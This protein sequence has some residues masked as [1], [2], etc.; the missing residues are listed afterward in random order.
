MKVKLIPLTQGKMAIVSD[1]DYGRVV[2]AGKWQAHRNQ[3]GNWY[4][5]RKFQIGKGKRKTVFM[6]R[7]IMEVTDDETHVD[8]LDGNGLNNARDNLEAVSAEENW[9]R[10][11]H[12]Q[13]RKGEDPWL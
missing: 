1:R 8:H 10:A 6:H 4:A 9:K 3:S 7:F 13:H 11:Y 5:K 2:S 12:K